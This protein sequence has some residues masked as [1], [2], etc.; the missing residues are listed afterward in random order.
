VSAVSGYP[1]AEVE[2]AVRRYV[3]DAV[4]RQPGLRTVTADLTLARGYSALGLT[5][6]AVEPGRW[7]GPSPPR[8]AL[9]AQIRKALDKITAEGL[10]VRQ[11]RFDTEPTGHRPYAGTVVYWTPTGAERARQERADRL[12]KADDTARRWAAVNE[13]LSAAGI[14][15]ANLPTAKPS[16]N[17]ATWEYLVTR[18]LPR[19]PAVTEAGRRRPRP[20]SGYRWTDPASGEIVTASPTFICVWEPGRSNQTDSMLAGPYPC[21]DA[22]REPAELKTWYQA[23]NAEGRPQ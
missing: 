11:G 3:A 13:G 17:L 8:Q 12:A 7:R 9:W 23:W 19:D 14:G 5:E 22:V 2:E 1:A 10:L 6:P 15:H 16:L 21:P 4:I 18:L 20:A